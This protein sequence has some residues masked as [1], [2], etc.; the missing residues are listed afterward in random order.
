[1]IFLPQPPEGWGYRHGSPYPAV[2]YFS[3]LHIL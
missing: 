2:H 3:F 1:V